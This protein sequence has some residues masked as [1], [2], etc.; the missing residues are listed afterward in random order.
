ML[1]YLKNKSGTSEKKIGDS[2]SNN[3]VKGDLQINLDAK[4][5]ES[6]NASDSAKYKWDWPPIPSQTFNIKEEILVDKEMKKDWQTLKTG[7]V[8]F[9]PSL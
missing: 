9:E 4:F 7:E 2:N 6:I 5:D 8:D 3:D 1:K